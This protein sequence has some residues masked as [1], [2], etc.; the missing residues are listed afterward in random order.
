[1]LENLFDRRRLVNIFLLDLFPKTRNLLPLFLRGFLGL[2]AE[3]LINLV[4]SCLL[5]G[6][7]PRFNLIGVSFH[8]LVV[9]VS[10]FVHVVADERVRV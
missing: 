7:P 8:G 3:P 4:L 6:S 10:L 9:H 2:L 5:L 1:M